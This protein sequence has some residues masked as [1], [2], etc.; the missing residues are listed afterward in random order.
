[1]CFAIF[2]LENLVR[3]Y[4]YKVPEDLAIC[5]FDDI[6]EAG[7]PDISLTT[8]RQPREKIISEALNL[9]L[10]ERKSPDSSVTVEVKPT[11]M[12]RRS[13]DSSFVADQEVVKET[14]RKIERRW[15]I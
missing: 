12:I 5:G 10:D 1:D 8:V 9:L 7:K 4:S 15:T 3:R 6:S 13:T 14:V 2:F 11:L